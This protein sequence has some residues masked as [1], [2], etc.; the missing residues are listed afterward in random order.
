MARVCREPVWRRCK[1][2]LRPR[3][4]LWRGS[5][6]RL[7]LIASEQETT[8]M[9]LIGT[10]GRVEASEKAAG[11]QISATARARAVLAQFRRGHT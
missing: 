1:P 4:R 9:A 6:G 8:K 10:V 7:L 2:K 11:G 3:R 5:S